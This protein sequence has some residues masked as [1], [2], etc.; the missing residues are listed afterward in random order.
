[1]RLVINLYRFIHGGP[2]KVPV[3]LVIVLLQNAHQPRD[4]DVVVVVEMAKPP[5]GNENM[6]IIKHFII[7]EVVRERLYWQKK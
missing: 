2:S 1:M 7:G 3:F 6:F 5:V 4:I